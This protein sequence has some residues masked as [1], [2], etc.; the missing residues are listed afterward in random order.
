MNIA[1]RLLQQ[2]P[3]I[4]KVL[5]RLLFLG[6]LVVVPGCPQAPQ[7]PTGPQGVLWLQFAQIS[8]THLLDDESPARTVRFTDLFTGSWRPQE[9]YTAQ[10]LD[11]TLRVLNEYHTGT[12]QPQRHLDFLIH[13]GDTVDNAQYN[14]LRWFVE[15]MNGLAVL[16]DSGAHEGQNRAQAPEDNPKL[17]FK[18][19]GLLPE[20][21]WYAVQGNHDILC[22]GIFSIDRRVTIPENW[23]APQLEPVAAL[24][25]LHLFDRDINFLS[26][27]A[28]WNPAIIPGDV[29]LADPVTEKLRWD[30]LFAGR[31]VPD[32]N[33]HFIDSEMFVSEVS[34]GAVLPQPADASQTQ[35]ASPLC[36]SVRPKPDVPIRLVVLD[37]TVTD[38]PDGVPTAHGVLTRDRFEHFLKDQIQAARDA[39]EWVLLAT[40][41]PS[42][43][44]SI[45]YLGCNV[46]Q[47]EFR[48]YLAE[49]PNFIA[50]ICGHTHRNHLEM[51]GGPH[52]YPEI[53]TDSI[54]DYPQEARILGIYWVEETQSFRVESTMVSHMDDPTRLS[55]E[56]FRRA[57]IISGHTPDPAAFTKR[58]SMAP[59]EVLGDISEDL[60]AEGGISRE[61]HYGQEKDRDF[62]ITLPCT[63]A[64]SP[65]LRVRK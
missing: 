58:Y 16:T 6:T 11:A 29:D 36:Y 51:V 62:S 61:E 46:G 24:L 57:S 42:A 43:N 45:P 63:G 10:T 27:T 48:R 8:D 31:I 1:S 19:T 28:E 30:L 37:T 59:K 9:A 21:P 5:L 4:S 13:T 54:I 44:F 60:G 53:E 50:H 32:M 40:H 15:V 26:P 22:T 2:E 17:G 65:E 12:L 33:R 20:I 49:Q 47:G 7:V 35:P 39:G 14:E 55:A 18:A 64:P 34:Q 41:H 25:G 23:T 3:C 38:P 56:S 52:P